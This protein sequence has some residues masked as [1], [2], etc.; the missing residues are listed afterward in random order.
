MMT[1]TT[2]RE[3]I[4]KYLESMNSADFPLNTS[5]LFVF[6]GIAYNSKNRYIMSSLHAEGKIKMDNVYNGWRLVK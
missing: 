2:N 6:L 5:E 3:R 4:I 1:R